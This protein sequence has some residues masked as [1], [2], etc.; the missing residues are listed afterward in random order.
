MRM[1][2]ICLQVEEGSNQTLSSFFDD[3]CQTLQKYIEVF[4]LEVSLRESNNIIQSE[5]KIRNLITFL[6]R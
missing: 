3:D 6:A 5:F 4:G 2:R 1:C